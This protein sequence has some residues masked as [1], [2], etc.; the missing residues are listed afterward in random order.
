MSPW[1]MVII[2]FLSAAMLLTTY[3]KDGPIYGAAG[4][5]LLLM[6]IYKTIDALTDEALS[7]SW[8]VWVKRGVQ[9]PMVIVIGYMTWKMIRRDKQE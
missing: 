7:Y 4:V 6:G 2:C 8:F 3:R 5:C 1:I 9:L